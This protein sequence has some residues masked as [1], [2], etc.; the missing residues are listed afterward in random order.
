MLV[1][2]FRFGLLA[3]NIML[4]ISWAPITSPKVLVAQLYMGGGRSPAEKGVSKRG[5]FLQL[6]QKLKTAAE[7]PGFF[8]VGK[9]EPVRYILYLE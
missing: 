8:Q 4:S 1:N 3:I 2:L 6:Q 5:M 7:L 9:G